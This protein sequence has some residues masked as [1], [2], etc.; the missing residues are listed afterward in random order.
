MQRNFTQL[1]KWY[2]LNINAMEVKPIG[3]WNGKKVKLKLRY[4]FLTDEDLQYRIGKEKEMIEMLGN[5]IGVP[6]RTIL[7]IIV[8]I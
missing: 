6:H 8:S 2:K 5:K 3:Y 7:D 1:N 4:P